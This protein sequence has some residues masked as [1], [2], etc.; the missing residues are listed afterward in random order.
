VKACQIL[1]NWCEDGNGQPAAPQLGLCPIC[2]PPPNLSC[3]Q[4]SSLPRHPLDPLWQGGSC[5]LPLKE[6]GSILPADFLKNAAPA[7]IKRAAAPP[8]K[9]GYPP[10]QGTSSVLPSMA[11]GSSISIQKGPHP[12]LSPPTFRY[13][14]VGRQQS[15][16]V[17]GGLIAGK[18]QNSP[19]IKLN[20]LVINAK[21]A[22][23]DTHKLICHFNIF[24][25]KLID[26]HSWI[27]ISWKPFL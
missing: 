8:L 19:S 25:P 11:L 13:V 20:A 16:L 17:C 5:S 14:A 21:E 26:L 23:F 9:D 18:S 1:E 27:S 3:P 12:F 6:V 22:Y 4:N 7:S 15:L 2:L 24:W 10:M